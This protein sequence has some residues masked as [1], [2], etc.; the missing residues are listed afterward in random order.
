MAPKARVRQL[1][2]EHGETT[3]QELATRVDCTR[4]PSSARPSRSASS[5]ASDI[6]LAESTVMSSLPRSLPAG[7]RLLLTFFTTSVRWL[8]R[9]DPRERRVRCRRVT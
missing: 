9:Q 7:F 4:Q 3:Q 1:R 2:T 5:W 8:F 6:T